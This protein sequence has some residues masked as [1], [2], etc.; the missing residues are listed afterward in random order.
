MRFTD[1]LLLL[2]LIALLLVAFFEKTSIPYQIGK[3]SAETQF[4][5]QRGYNSFV[6][7]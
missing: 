7:K 3:I 6:P 4:E 1:V 2:V 5:F